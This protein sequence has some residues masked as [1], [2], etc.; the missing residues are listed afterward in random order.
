MLSKSAYS[1]QKHRDLFYCL[2]HSACLC[3]AGFFQLLYFRLHRYVIK[4]ICF[5]HT[6]WFV[7]E[8]NQCLYLQIGQWIIPSSDSF[9]TLIHSGMKHTL[10]MWIE[11]CLMAIQS[12]CLIY[13]MIICVV[14]MK[15]ECT[16]LS[17]SYPCRYITILIFKNDILW[18]NGLV[19]CPSDVHC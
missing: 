15:L 4:V 5:V 11:A 18:P 6:H 13:I 1:V 8:L 7:Q 19:K 14:W 12:V 2:D 10:Y 17:L 16:M 3:S 9:V